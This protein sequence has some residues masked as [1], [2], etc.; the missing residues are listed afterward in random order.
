MRD[1]RAGDA[2]PE[3]VLPLI[4]RVR[5]EHGKHEILDERLAQIIDEDFSLMPSI[6]AFLRAGS[7]LALAQIGGEGD[8]LAA[9]RG[10][11]P[12]EDHEVSSPPE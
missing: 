1:Q 11:Q 2:S 4:E 5:P 12:S 6:C 9:I 8:H 3:Q 7:I 10:L